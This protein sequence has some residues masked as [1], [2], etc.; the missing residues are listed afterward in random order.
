MLSG[1]SRLETKGVLRQVSADEECLQTKN[2]RSGLDPRG[3]V[4]ALNIPDFV[5]ILFEFPL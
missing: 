2:I 1:D 5:A 3:K 4:Q